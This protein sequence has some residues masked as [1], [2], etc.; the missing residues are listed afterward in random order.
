MI[1]GIRKQI[2]GEW[3]N[4]R[5]VAKTLLALMETMSKILLH[6]RIL[7]IARLV[8]EAFRHPNAVH[9][10][11]LGKT[12]PDV[13]TLVVF[14]VPP[15]RLPGPSARADADHVNRTVRWIVVGIA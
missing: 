11:T 3:H 15:S 6:D 2:A 1:R 4:A 10:V 12:D 8:V 14:V 7:H 13:L 5:L 9:T